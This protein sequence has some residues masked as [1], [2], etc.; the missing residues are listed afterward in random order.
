M[1]YEYTQNI[2]R[3]AVVH[4]LL[5]LFLK[6]FA[7]FADTFAFHPLIFIQNYPYNKQKSYFTPVHVQIKEQTYKIKDNNSYRIEKRIE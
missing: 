2:S 6:I 4:V 1:Y 5:F 7:P 3:C